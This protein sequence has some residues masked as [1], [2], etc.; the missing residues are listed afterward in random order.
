MTILI[1]DKVTAK[2]GSGFLYEGQEGEVLASRTAIDGM[3]EHLIKFPPRKYTQEEMD[4]GEDTFP[5][6]SQ[7]WLRA[8]EIKG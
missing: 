7:C 6:E 5:P 2:T 1:G 3:I 4:R 8:D